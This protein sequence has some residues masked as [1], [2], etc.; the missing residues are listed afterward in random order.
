MRVDKLESEPFL[1][2]FVKCGEALVEQDRKV[3]EDKHE[4][5][6]R[7]V[8]WEPQFDLFHDRIARFMMVL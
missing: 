7:H 3:G 6:S 8:C 2:L 1:V 5:G 4:Q